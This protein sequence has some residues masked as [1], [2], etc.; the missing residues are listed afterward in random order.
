MPLDEEERDEFDGLVLKLKQRLNDDEIGY[1]LVRLQLKEMAGEGEYEP[2]VT[3]G[4]HDEKAPDANTDFFTPLLDHEVPVEHKDTCAKYRTLATEHDVLPT[5][6]IC[7]R[8]RAGFTLK[9]HAP[10]FGPC[11]QNFDYLQDWNFPDDPTTDS[12]V[13]WVPRLL[14]NSTS[15]TKDQQMKL[16]SQLRTKLELPAHHLTGFGNTALVAG[17]ILAHHKATSECIPLNQYYVRTETCFAGGGRL[18]LHW[19]GVV[20]YCDGWVFGDHA[21]GGVGVFALGVEALGH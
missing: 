1:G 7:Y 6:P 14:K 16:L 18:A 13:F 17:L 10:K 9:H 15:K 21:N 5:T 4:V 19:R 2:P 3:P 11:H 12:L 20:L 8:V